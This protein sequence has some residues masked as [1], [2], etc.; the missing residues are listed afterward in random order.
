MASAP[1]VR[2][3][4]VS[5]ASANAGDMRVNGIMGRPAL[6]CLIVDRVTRARQRANNPCWLT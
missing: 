5:A 1:A 3:E 6:L 2:T 4:M